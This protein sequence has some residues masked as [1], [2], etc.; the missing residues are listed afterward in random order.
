MK[1]L[2]KLFAILLALTLMLGAV[3]ASAEGVLDKIK[4]SGKIIIGTEATYG[5]YEFPDENGQPIGCDIWLAEKIA[6]AL[7]VKPVIV[8]VDFMG[9]IPAVKSGQLDIGIAAF[10]VNEDRKEQI[11][12]TNQ[13]ELSEQLLIVKKGNGEAY[14]TKDALAGLKVGAQ[15]GTVQSQLITSALPDSELFELSTY[16]D[17][18]LEVV[19]G[20]IAGFVADAAVGLGFVAQNDNLEVASLAFTAEEA[21]FGKACVIAKGNADLMEIVNQVI[22]Q[23]VADGSYLE[24]FNYYDAIWKGEMAE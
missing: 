23:V 10:T 11:D 5:P 12:F 15:L 18:A 8:D 19:N 14:S 20:S 13:Y 1:S 6:E 17:L 16:P 2:N 22:D 9:I 24:M 3:S 21:S 4:V 7:G